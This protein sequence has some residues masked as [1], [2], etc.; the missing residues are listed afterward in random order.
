MKDKIITISGIILF[1]IILAGIIYVNLFTGENKKEVY[2]KIIIEG[3]QLQ[4]IDGYL[5]SSDL[6][7]S[8]EYSDLT[9]QEVKKRIVSHPY[10]KNAEVQSDGKG[11]INIRIIEKEFMAVLLTNRKPFLLTDSFEIIRMKMNS[12]ISELPVI[13]NSG[14]SDIETDGKNAK[15]DELVRALKIIEAFKIVDAGMLDQLA[16]INLRNGRDVILSFNGIKYPVIFGKGSEGE[17]IVLLSA[18][19]NKMK[20]DEKLFS[21]ST[22][23]DLRFNNEIF[24]GKPVKADNNG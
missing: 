21:N 14:I 15:T 18:I 17:K 22:Y 16:E 8:V 5:M 9:L 3:N 23:V 6:N 12:D 20:N 11:V 19:W 13:S 4:S 2:T 7:K 24:I 1:A 10:V